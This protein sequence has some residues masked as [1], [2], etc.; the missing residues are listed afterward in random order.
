MMTSWQLLGGF[1][2][3]STMVHMSIFSCKRCQF[4]ANCCIYGFTD[5]FCPRLG[6]SYN[7]F[8]QIGQH[9]LAVLGLSSGLLIIV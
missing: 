7:S 3:A 6:E 5:S 1:L 8:S 9:I 2:L 4:T